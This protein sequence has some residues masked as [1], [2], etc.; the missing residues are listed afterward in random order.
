MAR[1]SLQTYLDYESAQQ[2]TGLFDLVAR[3]LDA[4]R[5]LVPGS[6]IHVAPSLFI[7]EVVYVDQDRRCPAFFAD[8]EVRAWLEAHRRYDTPLVMRFHHQDYASPLSEPDDHFDLLVSQYAGIIS[9]P[10]ARHLTLGGHLLANDSH[11]DAG[12]AF[13]DPRYALVAVVVAGPDRF[14][15]SD[16]DLEGYFV[17]RG[18]NPLLTIEERIAAGRGQRYARTADQYLFQRVG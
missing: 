15:L 8:P 14:A 16:D 18:R 17:P 11:G 4:R 13:L 10:C 6:W 2:R 9:Q 12:V 1:P 5:A 3:H 7:P